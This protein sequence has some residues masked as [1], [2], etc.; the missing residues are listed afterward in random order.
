MQRELPGVHIL[1]V[2]ALLR[3]VVHVQ[4]EGEDHDAGRQRLADRARAGRE[5][6]NAPPVQE[7]RGEPGRGDRHHPSLFARPG[8]REPGRRAGPAGE[9]LERAEGQSVTLSHRTSFLQAVDV[10]FCILSLSPGEILQLLEDIQSM[11]PTSLSQTPFFQH[12]LS[13]LPSLRG[14]IK[15]AVTAS[16]KQWLLEIRNVS[17][18]VGRLALESMEARIRRWRTRREKDPMLRMSRVGSAVEAVTYE[19]T[20]CEWTSVGLIVS[21]FTS[22]CA[23]TTS[24][25]TTR[26]K[27]TL[28]HFTNAF[29]FIRCSTLSTNSGNHTKPI[30]R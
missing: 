10:T 23:Q 11:P 2:D 16:M 25:K 9:I 5:E 30:G 14:Q 7:D 12:L 29:I 19:K 21:S 1:R 26:F 28:D 13:S 20:E 22:F 24:F 18:E 15:D 17:A 3:Q 4:A 8:R 27:W 6:A